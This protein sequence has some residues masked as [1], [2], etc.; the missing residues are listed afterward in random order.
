MLQTF[1]WSGFCLPTTGDSDIAPNNS[2]AD[3]EIHLKNMNF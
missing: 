2:F 3:L 1:S